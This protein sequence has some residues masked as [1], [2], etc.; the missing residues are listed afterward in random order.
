MKP[1]SIEM[2]VRVDGQIQCTHCVE[3]QTEDGETVYLGL[4]YL[5]GIE[6]VAYPGDVSVTF[7]GI[8]RWPVDVSRIIDGET[9]II[10]FA[11]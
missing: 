7:D 9:Q 2:Y 4:G 1:V 3:G 5:P 11:F 8:T 10:G 6:D